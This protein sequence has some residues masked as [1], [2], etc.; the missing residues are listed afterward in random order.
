M[1]ILFQEKLSREKLLAIQQRKDAKSIVIA[2]HRNHAFELIASVLNA[3]LGLSRLNASFWY[4]GYDDSFNFADLP[5]KADLHLIWIDASHY[6]NIDFQAWILSRIAHLQS[7]TESKILVACFA[8]SEKQ[9]LDMKLDSLT[10]ILFINCDNV[11]KHLGKTALDLRLAKYTGTNLSNEACLVLARELGTRQI[12]ALLLPTLKAIILDLDNT[13]YSG[14]L[15]EDGLLKV[16]PNNELQAF[17]LNLK[18]QGFLLAIA[19]KNNEEDVKNLFDRRQDFVLAWEDFAVITAGWDNK[20]KN[21]VK[22]ATALNIGLD[23]I[24]FIDDNPAER[25]HVGY[26]L[27]EVHVLEANTPKEMLAA[28]HYYPGLYKTATSAEDS[29]RHKDVLANEQRDSLRKTLAPEDYLKELGIALSFEINPHHHLGRMA[30]LL[31]KTNQFILSYTRPSQ[32]QLSKLLESKNHCL[33]SVS[34][35]D[36]LSDSGLIAVGI[37]RKEEQDLHLEELVISCRALGRE[38]EDGLIKTMLELAK[39][40]LSTTSKAFIHYITG[41]RNQPALMW[42]QQ[43]ATMTIEQKPLASQTFATQP[44]ATQPLEQSGTIVLAPLPKASM[45]HVKIGVN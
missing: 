11:I 31:N 43:L 45:P 17:L 26:K 4:S 24:V 36:K 28:L 34:M 35:Q 18:K 25:L 20:A 32:S 15:G 13:L 27:P 6:H 16:K 23:S 30:E 14:I 21:I 33:I 8:M 44:L 41:E 19:S 1:Q 5:P 7:L 42:L 10:D 29:L 40:K 38:V 9:Q 12:P 22:I 3:F 39:E 2:V 37:I